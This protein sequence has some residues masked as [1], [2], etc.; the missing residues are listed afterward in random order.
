MDTIKRFFKEVTTCDVLCLDGSYSYNGFCLEESSIAFQ[1]RLH[2]LYEDAL[3]EVPFLG[4]EVKDCFGDIIER[5]RKIQLLFDAPD[6]VC[7]DSMNRD[8]EGGNDNVSLRR[9]RDFVKMVCECVSLQKY[10]L[11]EFATSIGYTTI[12][13]KQ[14]VTV[15]AETKQM[16]Q[17]EDEN[18]IK[19]VE[20]LA[21]F[22]GCGINSAQN[23]INSKMLEAEKV[24]YRVGKAWRF[25][26]N[27][28]AALLEKNPA[29]FKK[30]QNR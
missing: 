23:I 4:Q 11:N 17:S 19:G 18:I 28:L 12:K 16:A 29:I 21:K 20:G 25:N 1:K 13:D 7:L 26:K 22:L 30:I 2:T 10:Y 24:Q 27:K 8:I 6:E 15:E 14:D 5:Y 9:E 3:L